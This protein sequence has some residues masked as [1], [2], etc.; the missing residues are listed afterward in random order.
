MSTS[1]SDFANT[2]EKL[3]VSGSNWVIWERRFTIAV[4]QKEVF[5]HFDRTCVKPK[6]PVTVSTEEGESSGDSKMLEHIKVLAAWQKKED[7]VMHLLVQKLPDSTFSKCMREKSVAEMWAVIVAEFTEKSMLM[8]SHLYQEFMAMRY[9][10]GANLRTELDR[11]RMKY[12]SLYSIGIEVSDNDYCTLVINFLPANLSNFVVQISAN[13]VM[14]KLSVGPS[15]STSTDGKGNSLYPSPERLMQSVI[16]EWEHRETWKKANGKGKAKEKEEDTGTALATV[17]SEKPGAKAGG[18]KDKK[19]WKPRGK[20]WNCGGKGHKK[21]NCPSPKKDEDENK[22]SKQ[23]D[24]QSSSSKGSSKSNGSGSGSKDSSSKS[25]GGGASAV[26]E[27]VKGAWAVIDENFHVYDEINEV[28]DLPTEITSDNGIGD[29]AA[30]FAS[31]IDDEDVE[32]SKAAH[33]YASTVPSGECVWD[34]Y[35][36]GAS[37]HM[38]PCREDFVTLHEIAPKSLTAANKESFMAHGIGDVIISVPNGDAMNRMQL[39]HVLYTPAIGFTL[40]SI[41]RIDDAGYF[42]L[43]GNGRCETRSKDNTIVGIIPKTL[44]V[45]RSE[46]SESS[47]TAPVIGG[48]MKLTLRQLHNKLGHIAASTLRPLVKKGV[49]DGVVV[50]DLND[51]FECIACNEVKPKWKSVP[52]VCEGE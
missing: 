39:T 35:D 25:G 41:G 47:M 50:V 40:I 23:K 31:A 42:L 3:D 8:Q 12:Q 22:E 48:N 37:H 34:L 10:K 30:M 44:G 24:S 6:V 4:R 21:P 11:V 14:M 52:K 51:D 26:D 29:N 1:L 32:V 5:G 49:I 19:K 43:F 17:S 13:L 36:S 9:E 7:L 20:C 15:S 38:S 45:Y 16:E 28:D 46:H 33:A 18:G 2:I 27:E